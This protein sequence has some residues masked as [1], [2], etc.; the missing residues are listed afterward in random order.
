MRGKMIGYSGCQR[1]SG[2]IHCGWAW[3]SQSDWR[4]YLDMHIEPQTP[5]ALI[6]AARGMDAAGIA[7]VHVET[8]QDA[9]AGLLPEKHLLRLNAQS[10]A[11]AWSRNLSRVEGP[12][13]TLVAS[14]DDDVVGFANFG[15]ARESRPSREGEIFML[16]VATDWRERGIGRQLMLASFE[17]LKDAGSDAVSIWCL[18]E[19]TSAIGF[20]KRL[21]GKRIPA[22]RQENVGGTMFPVT[23]FVWAMTD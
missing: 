16:Y 6:R 17:A 19:N 15:N 23:G 21:G 7:R 14:V 3:M 11:L 8:W 2:A 22:G 9:Y 20:Y 1:G 4:E 18:A 12:R 5:V 10:H 13:H